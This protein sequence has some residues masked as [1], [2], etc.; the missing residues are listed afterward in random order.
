MILVIGATGTVGRHVVSGLLGR[1]VKVRALTRDLGAAQLPPGVEVVRGDVFDAASVGRHLQ[2]VDAVFL[3]WPSFGVEGA[4]ELVATLANRTGRLVYLSAE[5]ARRRPDSAWAAVEGSIADSGVEW[6]F[7][8]PTGFAANTLM[9]APQIRGSGVVR[10]PYGRAARSLIHERDV[11]EVAVHA[12]TVD[13]HSGARHVLT[14]PESL[15][16]SEQ[17]AVIG[18]AIGRPVRWEELSRAEAEAQLADVVPD[19]A[20]DTWAAFVEAPE[21]VTST[22][23]EVTGQPARSFAEW[24]REHAAAFR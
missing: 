9:W 10:W 3:V 7:L 15:T 16:Q 4:D 17:A 11:A 23:Q 6:T 8:R 5:A 22:V 24:A 13:G 18:E 20:L 19:T 1:D 14:G 12:L 2:G 21:V